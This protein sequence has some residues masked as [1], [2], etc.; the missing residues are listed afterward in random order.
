MCFYMHPI[1]W[2]ELLCIVDGIY[3]SGVKLKIRALYSFW[4]GPLERMVS[5]FILPNYAP[6][7]LIKFNPPIGRGSM[8]RKFNCFLF[9]HP[10][11]AT[12]AHLIHLTLVSDRA[13]IETSRE[14]SEVSGNL[15]FWLAS[16]QNFNLGIPWNW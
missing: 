2:S 12:I 9:S 13:R 16:L 11:S 1:P 7:P 5:I 8:L 14:D 10:P 6:F 15:L 4:S 3:N